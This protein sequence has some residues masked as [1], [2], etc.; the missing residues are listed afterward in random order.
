MDS[1]AENKRSAVLALAVLGV[2]LIGSLLVFTFLNGDDDATEPSDAKPSATPAQDKAAG[3][4]AAGGG[5]GGAGQQTNGG[6]SADGVPPMV[7]PA[8]LAEAH[9]AMAAYM[10]GLSTYTYADQT[11][12]W[13][14]PLL[15]LTV[16]DNQMKS[17]T[18]L[19]TGKDWA[20][21]QANRC[22]SVG[23]AT[24]VRDGMIAQDLV[25]GGGTLVSSVV[26]LTTVRSENGKQTQTETNSW[27]VST[28]KEAGAWKVSAF[29]LQGLGNVGASEQA[30]E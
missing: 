21:C 26:S 9:R 6:G 27:L 8:E 11:A 1:P 13:A 14:K 24:V 2:L 4:A 29:N 30:G 23:K 18:V 16:G 25:N 3:T 20:T 17:H 28:R 10:A 7:P 22:S 12:A 15:E 19:P 5:S